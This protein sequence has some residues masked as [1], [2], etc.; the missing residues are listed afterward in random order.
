MAYRTLQQCVADL[1]RAGQLIR[2]SEEISADLE[3]AE[4]QRRVYRRGGPAVLFERVSGC[5]FPMVSNLFGTMDRA[6]FIFRDTLD[7]VRRLIELKIDPTRLGKAP[8]KSLRSL[9][10]VWHMRPR[11]VASG[12]VSANALTI[13][14]LPQLKS[15]PDDGGA[16]ITLP[17]VYTEDIR[18]PGPQQCQS[19][20]VSRPVIG[21]PIRAQSAKWVCTISCIAASAC[22]TPR[23]SNEECRCGSTSSW[24][25]VL[26]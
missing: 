4:I 22:I 26:R 25:A 18:H 14:Q 10:T 17:Q 24:V 20:H 1:E 7:H 15:W 23:R 16:Y 5:R 11:R 3:A 6:R 13:D 2:L 19:G 21:W 8:W 12:P 9:P